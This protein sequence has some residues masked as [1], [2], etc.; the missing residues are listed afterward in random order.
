MFRIGRK[1]DFEKTRTALA[2]RAA[3]A[4]T[5]FASAEEKLPHPASAK[6]GFFMSVLLRRME[7]ILVQTEL[8]AMTNA[9]PLFLQAR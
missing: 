4:S 9:H 6:T 5:L 1:L 3:L 2:K 8:W 7:I